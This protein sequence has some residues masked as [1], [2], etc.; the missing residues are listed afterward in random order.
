PPPPPPPPSPAPLPQESERYPFWSY[1]DLILFA[2]L[3]IPCMLLGLGLVKLILWVFHIHSAVRVVELLPEQFLG[4]VF[5]FWMLLLIFRLEYDRPF[6]SSLAWTTTQLPW[7]WMVIAGIS[8]A[9]IVAAVSNL[10]EMPAGGNPMMDLLSERTSLIL[11]A[12]FGVAV[13]PLCEELAFRGFLQPL[14]VR[15]LGAIPG[16]LLA[17]IPFGLL[18]FQ[19]YGR[20]WRHVVLISLAG[21]LF[22]WMRHATGSTMASTVMHAAYNSLGFF[23]LFVQR[24]G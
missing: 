11:M 1:G 4:Y 19:E 10:F 21:A 5:L 14:L 2:G 13:A 18:H 17:A 7:L 15:S 9:Y 3:T 6:W 16:I 23:A 12:I 22:G 24:K 8:A 20:S